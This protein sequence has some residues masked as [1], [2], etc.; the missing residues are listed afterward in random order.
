MNR[1]RAIATGVIFTCVGYSLAAPLEE[2]QRNNMQLG[3]FSVSLSVKDINAS[4]LFYEK[5]GFSQ[6]AGELDQRWVILQNE[7]TK[8]G[9]FQGMFEKNTLTF[10][11]GWNKL[12]ESL[13]SFEDVREIQDRLQANE[14]TLTTKTDPDGTGP[15]HIALIDPDGNPV[16]ID[17]HVP[18]PE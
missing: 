11:P 3:N 5:L 13:E 1:F 9:L 10:N 17:Q 18:K 15:G 2:K 6:I 8:I 14:I 12:G 4:K 16:L 7:D